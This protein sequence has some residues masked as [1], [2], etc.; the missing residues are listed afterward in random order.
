[1]KHI[2]IFI[3]Y[4]GCCLLLT[5]VGVDIYSIQDEYKAHIVVIQWASLFS[6]RAIVMPFVILSKYNLKTKTL[7]HSTKLIS[8]PSTNFKMI[9]R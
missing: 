3:C 8:V 7:R 1:M 6:T 2:N 9:K 5:V 4:C